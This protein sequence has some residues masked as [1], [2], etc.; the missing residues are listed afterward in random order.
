VTGHELRELLERAGL[1]QVGAAVP[2]GI[3]ARTMRR[4]LHASRVRAAALEH[5]LDLWLSAD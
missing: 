2:L 1:T 5:A 3:D 4:Y